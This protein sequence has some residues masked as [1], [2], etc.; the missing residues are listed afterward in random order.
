RTWEATTR[1]LM[2]LLEL[3][4]VLDI[5]SGDGLLA[6]LL[7]DHAQSVTCVD[8]S[9]AVIRAGR[10]QLGKH[11]HIDFKLGDMH[12]LPFADGQ[13]DTAFLMHA[14]TYTDQPQD[15]LNEAARILRPGG[16]LIVATLSQHDHQATVAEYD[17]INLGYSAAQLKK[18][19]AKSG[20]EVAECNKSLREPRAPYFEVITAR[21]RKR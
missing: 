2:Q 12:Q 13:F 15:V 7:S 5:A 10:R 8:I 1:A 11:P 19:L 3:G 16:Q 9:E 20:M 14:L 6:E 21:A 17:H 4:D 18:L